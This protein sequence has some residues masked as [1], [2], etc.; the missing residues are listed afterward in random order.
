MALRFRK[1]IKLAP[2]IRM[3]VGGSGVSWSVGPRGAK[4]NFSSRGTTATASAF[5]FSSSQRLSG[6]APSSQ[7]EEIA[8][9][10]SQLKT[11]EV[12]SLELDAERKNFEVAALGR[13]HETMPDPRIP[14]EYAPVP[15][16]IDKPTPPPP[17]PLLAPSIKHKLFKSARAQL[18]AENTQREAD[19][20]SALQR[21]RM[22]TLAPWEAQLAEHEAKEKAAG[23]LLTSGVRRSPEEMERALEWALAE[24]S[25]PRETTVSFSIADGGRRVLLDVDLPEVEDM[26]REVFSVAKRDR[27][28]VTKPMSDSKVRDLYRRHIHS[29]GL[30]LV[31]EV[32]AT[33]PVCDEAVISGYSQ[34]PNPKT[35]Q[36]EDQYLLS[37][38]VS[39]DA[40]MRLN[41]DALADVDPVEAYEMFELR[42]EMSKTGVFRPIDP[43][44]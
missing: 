20:A 34:R 30:R 23:D 28:L 22:E 41:F 17:L 11:L 19:N 9:L 26:P 29:V 40:W 1:S 27:E 14:R 8:A 36:V 33:L 43:L 32:F 6:H 31:G 5:G 3:N 44:Q 38:R 12:A 7:R 16:S 18:D 25:W 13:V 39:R 21:W 24:L 4:L 35:G 2:G 10:R 15:F 37:A 42:R